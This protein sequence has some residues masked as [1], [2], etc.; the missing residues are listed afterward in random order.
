MRRLMVGNGVVNVWKDT[1]DRRGTH[2]IFAFE[3]R[4]QSLQV[5]ILTWG[6]IRSY[7]ILINLWISWQPIKKC[8]K[9]WIQFNNLACWVNTGLLNNDIQFV[10]QRWNRIKILPVVLNRFDDVWVDVN[11]FTD[12][13][14]IHVIIVFR[15]VFILLCFFRFAQKETLLLLIKFSIVRYVRSSVFKWIKWLLLIRIHVVTSLGKIK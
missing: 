15:V 14:V 13:I 4:C 3:L 12:S 8:I 7:A 9:L 10:F 2:H 1:W 11:S 6:I 5:L